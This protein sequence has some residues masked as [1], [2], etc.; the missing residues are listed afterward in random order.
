MISIVLICSVL[1]SLAMGVLVA[2][3]V[4][5]GLFQMFRIHSRQVRQQRQTVPQIF[6]PAA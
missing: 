2:Y 5:I 6:R 4:C 3:A 1:A